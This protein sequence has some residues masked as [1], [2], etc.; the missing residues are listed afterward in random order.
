MIDEQALQRFEPLAKTLAATNMAQS[1]SYCME[2][3]Y[4]QGVDGAGVTSPFHLHALTPVADSSVKWISISQIGKPLENS[5]ENCFTAI[6]KILYSCFLPKEVQLLFLVVGHEGK[7]NMYIGLRCPGKPNPPRSLVKNLCNYMKGIWPGLKAEALKNGDDTLEYFTQNIGTEKFENVYALTGIPSMETQYKGLYPA[8]VDKLIAGLSGSKDYAYMVI[9]DPVESQDAE[10]MLY[11]CREMNGQAESLKSMNIT[12]GLNVSDTATDTVSKSISDAISYTESESVSKTRVDLGKKGKIALSV[13]GFG[14]AGAIFPASSAMLEAGASAGAAALSALAGT[15]GLSNVVSSLIPKKTVTKGTTHGTSHTDTNTTS[16]S[17]GHTEGRSHSMSRNM[18]NKHI[19]AIS[20]HLFYHGR[21]FETGKAIGLWKVG[22]YLAGEKESD[23]QAGALQLRSTISGQETI[24][25]PVR[26][27]NITSELE[28]VSGKKNIRALSLGEF[29]P[30]VISVQNSAG[31]PFKHPL[32][33]HFNDLRTILTTKE[34]SYLVNFPLRSV[35]GIS[36]IDSSPEFSLTP[37]GKNSYDEI[38]FGKLLYGGTPVEIPYHLSISDLSKHTLLSGINGSGKTNTVM[39]ILNAMSSKF[40]LP[41]LIIEPAKTEYVDWAVEYN[42]LHPDN[43]ITIYMPG[44]KVYR[45]KKTR[46]AVQ[47]GDLKLNPFEPVWLDKD[48]EPNVLSHIDRLKSTF[49][50]AFPMYDILPVLME[51]LIYSIYQNKSTDWLTS[52][53]VFGQTMPPT[54]NS[55]SAGVDKVIGNRQYEPRIEQNMKACLNT[56]IDSLK[57]GW[58]GRMLNTVHST[59]WNELFEKPVVINLSY[60]GDD[61]DKGFLMSLIM[62]LLYE[63][64]TACAELGRV[65]FNDNS[66]RHLTV[67]EEAHRVMM[68]CDKPDL[69]QYKTAMMFS[70]MLSEIR[71]YGEGMFLVDQVPTRLIPDAIKNTNTKIVHRL[72]AED[73]AKA[74][75]EAM[76]LSKEQ[77]KI[78]PK[79]LVGECLVSTALTPDKYWVKVNKSK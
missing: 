38:D 53:P 29:L 40:R 5:A 28:E 61:V 60:V 35:P 9:A 36:V 3:K 33:P 32:G 41:F 51:D 47:L 55:M 19:E 71:A 26:I 62:Q 13:A 21:R 30:P 10:A 43:P 25:E 6:Q 7:S 4:L 20:E 72:V 18:V 14:L 57:R 17:Q 39:A 67:I 12:E 58:K 66:C 11:N 44:C 48:Q 73:D 68:K 65:D 31:V 8:T 1:L 63:Y 64:R 22:V 16:H 42:K 79:L 15:V 75:A 49:A 78:I 52:E 23:L 27:H 24:Y 46:E 69:P 54:L 77:R 59:P 45:D 56:R 76:G 34:L 37:M 70:N 2:R 74:I 50:A